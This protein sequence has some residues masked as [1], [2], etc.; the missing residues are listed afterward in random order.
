MKQ[1]VASLPSY[2]ILLNIRMLLSQS[3]LNAVCNY[4]T[5]KLHGILVTLLQGGILKSFVI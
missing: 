1:M 3:P 4:F 2:G 5:K